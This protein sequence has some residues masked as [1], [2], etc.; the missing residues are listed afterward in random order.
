[1]DIEKIGFLAAKD[2]VFQD[3]LENVYIMLDKW[4]IL[5]DRIDRIQTTYHKITET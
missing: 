3:I 1:M 5:T 4:C 2:V